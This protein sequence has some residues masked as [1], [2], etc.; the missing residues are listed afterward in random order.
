MIRIEGRPKGVWI[1]KVLPQD[2]GLL[3]RLD[4]DSDDEFWME[5]FF[6][7]TELLRNLAHV[8]RL[9]HAPGIGHEFTGDHQVEQLRDVVTGPV[10]G[11]P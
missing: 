7:E 9:T 11:N 8:H 5:I 1:V 4:D 6:S 3:I 2:G 10:P